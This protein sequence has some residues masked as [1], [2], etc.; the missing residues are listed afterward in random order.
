MH[1]QRTK[2]IV[3]NYV[4]GSGRYIQICVFIKIIRL[5]IIALMQADA[6]WIFPIL[7]S[8]VKYGSSL[9]SRIPNLSK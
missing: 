2:A 3:L 8:G 4:L 5:L 9:Y 1:W 6:E 7:R